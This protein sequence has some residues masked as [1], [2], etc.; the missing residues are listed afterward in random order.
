MLSVT[1]PLPEGLFADLPALQALD[2]GA[3]GLTRAAL[4]GL[5]RLE[6]MSLTLIGA[7]APDALAELTSLSSL[8]LRLDRQD[9]APVGLL[10]PLRQQLQHLAV[11]N[12]QALTREHLAG[13]VQLVSR[14]R[15]LLEGAEAVQDVVAKDIGQGGHV[16]GLGRADD[17]RVQPLSMAQTAKA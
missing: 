15:N 10:A 14:G 5:H 2:L 11:S 7:A 8:T 1:S 17:H 9:G 6:R 13:L 12:G 4:R 3:P 16:G